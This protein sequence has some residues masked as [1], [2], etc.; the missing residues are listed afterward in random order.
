MR[1]GRRRRALDRVDQPRRCAAGPLRRAWP[2]ARCTGPK[3]PAIPGIETF[4]GHTFHTSRWDY[5]YTGGDSDG[6]LAG[7]AGK[8]VGII[9]TG[10]TAVQCVPAPGRGGRAPVRLPAHAVVD[11]RP[12]QPA[13]RSRVG[14]RLEPGW[15][16]R[17]M[18]NF[19]N[20]VSGVFEA[21]DLVDD[22]WTDIIGKLLLHDARGR[23]A[24]H[25]PDGLAR[26]VELAD[27][28]KMEQIRGRVDAIV[29]DP[30]TAEA[31]KP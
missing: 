1:V 2:T 4:Q 16:Q 12:R 10:A 14:S 27:F 15:Q 29:D 7:L 30:T 24:R 8:R 13:D 31:L 20:L 3:L 28:E 17:R 6:N 22:G 11:R 25:E 26:T 19:N 18:E 9:G 23:A 21:E 5:A